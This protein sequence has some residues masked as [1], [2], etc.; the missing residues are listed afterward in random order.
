MVKAPRP[1]SAEAPRTVR[2]S[3]DSSSRGRAVPVRSRRV[4]ADAAHGGSLPER[5]RPPASCGAQSTSR[6]PLCRRQHTIPDLGPGRPDTGSRYGERM[7][8]ALVRTLCFRRPHSPGPRLVRDIGGRELDHLMRPLMLNRGGRGRRGRRT[9]LS[10]VH[11]PTRRGES[12]EPSRP[13]AALV[14]GGVTTGPGRSRTHRPHGPAGRRGASGGEGSGAGP[15]PWWA[16]VCPVAVIEVQSR[17]RPWMHVGGEPSG[18]YLLGTTP[19]RR[20][21]RDG[22]PTGEAV[23]LANTIRASIG[24]AVDDRGPLP[25]QA[26]LVGRQTRPETSVPDRG[27]PRPGRAAT[28]WLTAPARSAVAFEQIH[29]Q[30]QPGCYGRL[31]RARPACPRVAMPCGGRGGADISAT[32]GAA[33]SRYPR[34]DRL[35]QLRRVRPRFVIF[36]FLR[37]TSRRSGRRT[38]QR[39]TPRARR[40]AWPPPVARRGSADR[41]GA[42]SP[43]ARH[44]PGLRAGRRPPACARTNGRP[45]TRDTGQQCRNSGA[46]RMRAPTLRRAAELR[47]VRGDAMELYLGAVNPRSVDPWRRRAWVYGPGRAGPAGHRGDAGLGPSAVARDFLGRSPRAGD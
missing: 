34:G 5:A 14:R 47:P 8:M 25:R 36:L 19:G 27:H 17:S 41:A 38:T 30:R 21:G 35:A 7:P 42:R 2:N 33:V 37:C 18:E 1:G 9:P 31:D 15:G 43:A 29:G 20:S 4:Q 40:G 22:G 39:G 3:A 28:G 12:G 24:R 11:H 13:G 32:C 6:G 10:A 23:R 46:A 45:G 26:R 16:G 44:R